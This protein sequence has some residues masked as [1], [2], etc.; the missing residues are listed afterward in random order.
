IVAA[1]TDPDAGSRGLSLFVVERE[2][3]GF[4]RGRKLNKI[5]LHGPDTAELSFTD[6]RIPADNLLGTEGRGL[7]HLMERLPRERLSIA[8]TGCAF[9]R[10][11]LNW[12]NRDRGYPG[13]PGGRGVAAG[14]G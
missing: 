14:P 8:V 9:V 7:V 10:A 6:A 13:P 3:P 2:T 1:T 12:T 5:G 4:E 11:A